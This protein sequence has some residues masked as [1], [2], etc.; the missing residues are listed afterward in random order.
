MR[1]FRG[2][3]TKI[4]AWLKLVMRTNRRVFTMPCRAMRAPIKRTSRSMRSVCRLLMGYARLAVPICNTWSGRKSFTSSRL[5]WMLSQRAISYALHLQST[6]GRLG[7]LR[8]ELTLSREHAQCFL[9]MF[10]ICMQVCRALRCSALLITFL[11]KVDAVRMQCC[12]STTVRG[13]VLARCSSRGRGSRRLFGSFTGND[14]HLLW[15]Y[16]IFT[17]VASFVCLFVCF[18]NSHATLCRAASGSGCCA[19]SDSDSIFWLPVLPLLLLLLFHF[20]FFA[21]FWLINIIY[22]WVSCLLSFPAAILINMLFPP[23]ELL[24]PNSVHLPICLYILCAC[25]SAPLCV[26]GNT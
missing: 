25:V 8:F 20:L 12:L 26:R 18:D 19:D 4:I 6:F 13:F 7:Y 15:L 21:I 10:C 17:F 2:F 11:M 5:H 22:S 1:Q 9:S 24:W 3:D 16:L 14:R 23:R